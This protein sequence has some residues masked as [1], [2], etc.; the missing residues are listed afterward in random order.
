[1]TTPGVPRTTDANATDA[2]ALAV[3]DLT[4][5]AGGRTIVDRVSFDVA[6]G[7][8]VPLALLGTGL[9]LSRRRTRR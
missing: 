8:I 9:A 7:E 1:M 3:E 4:L 2:S 6:A 5:R